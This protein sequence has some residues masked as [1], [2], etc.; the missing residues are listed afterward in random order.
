MET[1]FRAEY[2]WSYANVKAVEL[3]HIYKNGRK[4]RPSVIISYLIYLAGFIYSIYCMIKYHDN[5]TN[6]TLFLVFCVIFIC[7]P[8]IR[9][10]N[11]LRKIKN[12]FLEV[13][14]QGNT[15]KF[16]FTPDSIVYE[17]IGKSEHTKTEIQYASVSMVLELKQGIL[18][19]KSI[20]SGYF[21]PKGSLKNG[22]DAELAA[23]LRG[24][25]VKAS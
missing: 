23:F 1:Q 15:C 12:A 7:T 20:G 10:F 9:H 18:I 8:L 13:Q 22:T 3:H 6:L 19:Y 24:K 11:Y 21:I 17:K 25:I 4:I 16:E 5:P 2:Q 14:A